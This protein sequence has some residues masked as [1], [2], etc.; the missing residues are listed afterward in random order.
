[1]HVMM[2]LKSLI[3]VDLEVLAVADVV[4][5]LMAG[6]LSSFCNSM[7]Y[8]NYSCKLIQLIKLK[9]T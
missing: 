2:L 8:I 5:H 3:Y 6:S 9:L 1:M 4:F 7:K